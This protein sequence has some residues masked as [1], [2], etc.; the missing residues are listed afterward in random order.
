MKIKSPRLKSINYEII[1]D[2]LPSLNQCK[3]CYL[4][5]TT[6]TH[7]YL[8]CKKI[9]EFKKHTETLIHAIYPNF[10]E[11]TYEDITLQTTHNTKIQLMINIYKEIIYERLHESL[12]Q[13]VNMEERFEKKLDVYIQSYPPPS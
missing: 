6:T 11:I 4:C 7:S 10:N 3:M 9:L 5:I 12:T 2:L 13:A 1:Y 8:K